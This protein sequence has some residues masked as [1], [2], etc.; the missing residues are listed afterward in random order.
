MA[1]VIRDVDPQGA[2]AMALL[3]E[4]SADARALY[5]ELFAPDAGPARNGPL[6]PGDVYVAA[7]VDGMPL[8]CGALR[9][10]DGAV[11]ELRRM[12]VHREHRRRGLAAAVLRHL[13]SAALGLGYGRIVLET[14]YRQLP[15]MRLYE[16]C[17][18]ARIEPF[19]EHAGDPTSVCYAKALRRI[20][21]RAYRDA[22]WPRLCAIHDAARRDELGAAG[23]AGAYLTLEQTGANEG[24]FDA[25][26]VVAELDGI[27]RGFAAFSA[28]ELTWLYTD[29]VAY[30]QGIARALLRHAVAAGGDAMYAEVLVGNEA[31]LALYRSE[32]FAVLRRVD[33]KLAGNEAFAASGYY[34]E[35]RK[36]T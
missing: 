9:R 34:L 35:R 6:G 18:Y 2:D 16:R 25:N 30:R 5:P 12:Y 29:P 21:V 1:A 32:G 20:E 26:V 15:A 27:V 3:A 33:G 36:E 4:A 28:D 10:I 31:A 7:Y 23:L 24:L 22:D 13:E 14:G 8:A 19:G 17:G 11:A